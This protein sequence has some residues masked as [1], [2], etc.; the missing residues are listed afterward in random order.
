MAV[1]S[2]PPIPIAFGKS[3]PGVCLEPDCQAVGHKDL[4]FGNRAREIR[5]QLLEAYDC[6]CQRCQEKVAF[7]DSDL[8]HTNPD[9]KSFGLDQRTIGSIMAGMGETMGLKKIMREFE[10]VILLCRPCHR[11]VHKNKDP[12][13]FDPGYVRKHFDK[14]A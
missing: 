14:V 10:K 4:K 9:K 3:I 12:D 8:H 7:G 11:D 5:K 6:T 1:G 13:Y 2:I